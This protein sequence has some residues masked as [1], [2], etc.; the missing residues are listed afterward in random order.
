MR[1]LCVFRSGDGRSH[2]RCGGY[3][4]GKKKEEKEIRGEMEDDKGFFYVC[5]YLL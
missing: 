3:G 4:D 5:L 2:H 1:V